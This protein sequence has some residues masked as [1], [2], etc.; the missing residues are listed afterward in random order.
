MAMTDLQ[1]AM[2]GMLIAAVVLFAVMYA[3]AWDFERRRPK[4]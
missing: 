2:V 1:G 4:P 3:I